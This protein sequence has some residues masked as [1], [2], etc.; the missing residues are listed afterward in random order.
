MAQRPNILMIMTDQH[1]PHISGFGGNEVVNTRALDG[2]ASQSICFD[3]AYC[4]TPLCVPCRMSVLT[5]KWSSNCSAWDNSSII[6]P[7]HTTLPGWLSE[8]GYETGLVGKMH[9]SGTEQMHGFQHRPYGDLVK[10]RFPSHQPD[11]PETSDGRWNNH[12]VGRFPFAGP[13]AIPESLLMDAVV[14]TE[15]LSWLLEFVD[16]NPDSP[17]FFS[18]SYPRP[19]FPLTA[20]GRYFRRYLNRNLEMPELPPGYPDSLHPHDKFIVDDFNLV[21]FSEEEQVRALAGYYACVDFVDDCI[22]N[23]LEGLQ[24]AGCLD[25]TYVVYVSDHGDMAGEHGLWW[26]RTYYEAS[27]RVPFLVSGPGISAGSTCATPVELV[28]LFPTFCDWAEIETPEGLDGESLVPLLEGKERKKRIARSELLGEKEETQFRMVRDER[29]KYVE[30]PSSPP[31]LFDMIEDPDETQDLIQDSSCEAPIEMFSKTLAETG[32]FESLSERRT[33]DRERAGR[34]P[35]VGEGAVQYR[36]V[37]GRVV[38]GDG[39]LY[40]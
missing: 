2:L 19:H 1:S 29:W 9:F 5:G 10:S 3:A 17:W 34:A 15:S 13:T 20:P 25:N 33:L 35:V 6:F 32:T 23:L 12:A 40:Q 36:L 39:M 28:D 37:D 4:Q 38:D 14:T 30:F 16:T 24:R 11:P 22:G 21:K 18:A 26:K 8:H 31:R 27:A 7:E